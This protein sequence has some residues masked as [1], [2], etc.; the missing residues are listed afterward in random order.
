LA[1]VDAGD[2]RHGLA[3]EIFHK[4]SAELR[5]GVITND[6]EVETH[7]LLLSRLGRGVALDWL[8]HHGLAVLRITPEEEQAA[9]N[10]LVKHSDKSWSL[11]HAIA[12]A[13]ASARGITAA[14]S[15]DHHFRQF[16]RWRV[17]GL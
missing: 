15:F 13:V 12:F 17:L 1:L 8:L 11:C 5:P 14:F 3:I 2:D 6:I 7:A 4:L 9:R 16:G 10:L